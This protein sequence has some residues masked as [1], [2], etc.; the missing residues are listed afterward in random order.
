MINQNYYQS[1]L[2]YKMKYLELKQLYKGGNPQT[3]EECIKIR[4]K[5]D[6]KIL[7][8]KKGTINTFEEAKRIYFQTLSPEEIKKYEECL[9]VIYE[10]KLLKHRMPVPPQL[11]EDLRKDS[12]ITGKSWI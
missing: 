7:E 5:I 1:Y 2:K 6:E 11:P 4:D 12:L 8:I 10:A 9:K 3:E